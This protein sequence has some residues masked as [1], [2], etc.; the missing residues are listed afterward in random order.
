MNPATIRIIIVRTRSI[1]WVS[2][3]VYNWAR[4]DCGT[5]VAYSYKAKSVSLICSQVWQ[6][7]YL[8]PTGN[9]FRLVMYLSRKVNKCKAFLYAAGRSEARADAGAVIG[10]EHI[11]PRELLVS[12]Q[13]RYS[14]SHR[15]LLITQTLFQ[16]GILEESSDLP[17]ALS[18]PGCSR[19][20]DCAIFK[21]QL[22]F[23]GRF[24]DL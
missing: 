16:Y 10:L 23:S 2:E 19:V 13:K 14:S 20:G 4:N 1:I 7:F 15:D 12:I 22:P 24:L 21:S 17:T 3:F 8:L 6:L 5:I 11:F 9:R 18:P